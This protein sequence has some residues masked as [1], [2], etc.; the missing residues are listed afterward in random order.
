MEL[1]LAILF[2]DACDSTRLYESL[3]NLRAAEVIGTLLRRL[4]GEVAEVRGRVVK[5]LGDGLMCVFASPELACRAAT[6]MMAAAEVSRLDR[7]GWNDLRLR[8]GIHFGSVVSS[9]G[10][11]FGDAINVASRVE[12]MAS[13][14]ETLLTEAAVSRL[15]DAMR[16]RCRLIDTTRVK[17]KTAA[18]RI[19]ALHDR[20]GD[21]SVY[22]RTVIG[23]A[24]QTGGVRGAEFTLRLMYRDCESCISVRVPKLTIGRHV[25][26]DLVVASPLASRHHGSIEFSRESFVLTDHSSNGT[27][28]R[29]GDGPSLPLRREKAKL[30]G[31]G[32]LG[33]GAV[34]E[35]PDQAHVLRFVSDVEV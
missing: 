2:V 33:I 1:E 23:D 24:L 6:Q 25:S 30:V 8:I 3:G 32:W 18:I 12:T 29:A 16:G 9:G 35:R 22:D 14:A 4:E 11:I 7:R 26:C 19:Y 20:P 17:G 5:S 34:P 13:P 27:F 15:P 10:D 21:D 28:I 31:R